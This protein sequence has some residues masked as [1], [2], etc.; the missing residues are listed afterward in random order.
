MKQPRI[1]LLTQVGE[2]RHKQEDPGRET[3]SPK[4]PQ[5]NRVVAGWAFKYALRL[6]GGNG[7]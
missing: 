6:A 2:K 3:R 5:P 7:V 1:E 4:P